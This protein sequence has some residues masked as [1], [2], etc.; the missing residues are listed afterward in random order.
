MARPLPTLRLVI[1]TMVA[2][3]LAVGCG[4]DDYEKSM[5]EAQKRVE[6][7]DEE[8]RL[9]DAMVNIDARMAKVKMGESEVL[10][11]VP[12][13]KVFFRPPRGILP[14][15]IDPSKLDATKIDTTPRKE[16]LYRYSVAE[17]QVKP[18]MPQGEAV[19]VSDVYLG[20]CTKFV[21]KDKE[22]NARE[23]KS[24]T[25]FA[26]FDAFK[27]KVKNDNLFTQADIEMKP[28]E[29]KKM[30]E[31]PGKEPLTY[32]MW[33]GTQFIGKN[34]IRYLLYIYNAGD[35]GAVAI[36]YRIVG[37]AETLKTPG[38]PGAV[39]PV[40]DMSLASLLLDSEADAAAQAWSKR[41]P[42]AA[43]PPPK[44]AAPAK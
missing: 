32:S 7:F 33:E 25:E 3:L 28:A 35:K 30:V 14:T 44:P 4:M 13:A 6:R 43:A 39:A 9:L 18:I 15:V 23:T 27:D 31:V 5:I 34:A 8:N 41:G 11:S 21:G 2:S 17:G 29:A 22:G 1:L 19:S 24:A 12:V 20:F 37:P 38:A 26:N 10:D 16:F 36:V 42:M 40:I